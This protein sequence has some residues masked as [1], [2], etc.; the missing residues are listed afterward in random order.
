MG[1]TGTGAASH[2]AGLQFQKETATRFQFVPYRGSAPAMQDLVAGQIDFMFDVP[3]NSMPQVRAGKIKAYAST[4]KS[5]LAAASEVPT[6]DEAGLPGFYASNWNA[7]FVPKSTPKNVIGRLNAAVVD[8]LADTN[9]RSRLAEL[10]QDIPSRAQQTP[11][12]LRALQKAEIEKWWP[13]IKAGNIPGIGVLGVTAIVATAA[14]PTIFRSGRDF[15]AWI[16]LVPSD[17][18]IRD[19]LVE[20]VSMRTLPSSSLTVPDVQ[21]SRFRFFMEELCSRGCSDGR[22]ECGIES[23]YFTMTIALCANLSSKVGMPSGRRE[24]SAF[25]IYVLR[26]GGAM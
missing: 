26:T 11:E 4:A 19:S 3:T 9:V 1:T 14:D 12:A 2:I 16:G 15:A 18:T 23:K 10:G 22:W 20:K 5:R 8:A 25:G 7:L 6:V 17:H 13:I 24:P 21:I